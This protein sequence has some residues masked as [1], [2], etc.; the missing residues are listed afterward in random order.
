MG[1]RG[2][3]NASDVGFVEFRGG[4]D[5][6]VVSSHA[7]VSTAVQERASGMGGFMSR[8]AVL[9]VGM[10]DPAIE[11]PVKLD[12]TIHRRCGCIFRDCGGLM[13]SANLTYKVGRT[14]WDRSRRRSDGGRG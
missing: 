6:H 11:E 4:N 2:I 5:S 14:C 3:T 12:K 10:I 1:E 13:G 7:A 8:K 9:D